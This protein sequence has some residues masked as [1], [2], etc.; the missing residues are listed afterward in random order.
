MKKSILLIALVIFLM[1]LSVMVDSP[2]AEGVVGSP[3]GLLENVSSSL[4]VM[5][6][7]NPTVYPKELRNEYPVYQY[8]EWGTNSNIPPGVDDVMQ[9]ELLTVEKDSVLVSVYSKVLTKHGKG[10]SNPNYWITW[11]LHL[12]LG[13]GMAPMEFAYIHYG[14]FQRVATHGTESTK[15]LSETMISQQGNLYVPLKA[16]DLLAPSGHAVNY[17]D[18]HVSFATETYAVILSK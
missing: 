8:V 10:G 9:G 2:K 13:T 17:G 11:A 15:G 5:T 3:Q 1:G 7:N 6:A 18:G 4:T 16:G 12:G 14:D